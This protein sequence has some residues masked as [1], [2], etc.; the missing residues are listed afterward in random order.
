MQ[1]MMECIIITL[2]YVPE[3]VQL[4]FPCL[5]HILGV[6]MHASQKV[7]YDSWKFVRSFLKQDVSCCSNIKLMFPN[8]CFN[9]KIWTLCM[10]KLMVSIICT[11]LFRFY[12]TPWLQVCWRQKLT[13]SWWVDQL[14]QDTVDCWWEIHSQEQQ[15][16]ITGQGNL[17]VCFFH[18]NSEM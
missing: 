14:P 6:H 15:D 3:I 12:S 18:L 10:N 13:N 11:H 8:N 17:Q 4:I 9:R 2:I 5:A 7:L 1:C 16:D